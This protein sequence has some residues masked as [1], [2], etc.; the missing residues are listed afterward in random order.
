MRRRLFRRWYFA[1]IAISLI[2]PFLLAA[3]SVFIHEIVLALALGF[4]SSAN[5]D[6][7]YNASKRPKEIPYVI[8]PFFILEARYHKQ[9]FEPRLREEE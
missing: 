4:S 3:Y 7:Y 5:V 8:R 2:L 1:A 6:V 9:R